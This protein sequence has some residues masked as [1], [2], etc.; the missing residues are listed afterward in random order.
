MPCGVRICACVLAAEG[1]TSTLANLRRRLTRSSHV[2]AHS[3][4]D[5]QIA[6]HCV[7]DSQS[8][9]MQLLLRAVHSR[10]QTETLHAML[11]VPTIGHCTHL[12]RDSMNHLQEGQRSRQMKKW[13]VLRV[14]VCK[15]GPQ[16]SLTVTNLTR[17]GL[18]AASTTPHLPMQLIAAQMKRRSSSLSGSRTLII[19]RHFPRSDSFHPLPPYEWI[20]MYGLNCRQGL[21]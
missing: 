6:R 17:H 12:G 19:G 9:V 3:T 16:T 21:T 4:C 10:Q 8:T 20:C 15:I 1:G 14:V 11:E 7:L 2:N 18:T 13:T 5:L